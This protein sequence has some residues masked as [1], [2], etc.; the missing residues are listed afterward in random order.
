VSWRSYRAWRRA[1]EGVRDAVWLSRRT[2]APSD[3][4]G[5]L[6]RVLT[7]VLIVVAIIVGILA[8]IYLLR[9]A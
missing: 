5:T 6:C 8:I 4:G 3:R 9:R 2:R 1:G 7:T